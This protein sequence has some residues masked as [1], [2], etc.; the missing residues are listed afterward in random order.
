MRLESSEIDDEQVTSR[1]PGSGGGISLS[2]RSLRETLK[3]LAASM[4]SS[5]RTS[6]MKITSKGT[7]M[8]GRPSP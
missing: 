4:P 7:M 2:L 5:A 6:P 3:I 8:K 1:C